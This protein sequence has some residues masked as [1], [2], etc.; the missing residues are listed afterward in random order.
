LQT[1]GGVFSLSAPV[2]FGSTYGI[3]A[4]YL[5]SSSASPATAGVIRLAASDEIAWGASNYALTQSSGVL[6]WQGSTVATAANIHA[7]LG[8]AENRETYSAGA[9]SGNY[10]GSLTVVNMVGSYTTNGKNLHVFVNGL[11]TAPVLDYSETSTTSLTFGDPLTIG[12]RIDL[13][14]TGY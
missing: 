14:W 6:A 13:I 8:I 2:N 1:S 11:L 3:I 10:T 7:I 9:A 5:A 4:A 12:D